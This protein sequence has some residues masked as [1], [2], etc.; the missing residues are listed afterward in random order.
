MLSVETTAEYDFIKSNFDS[1]IGWI[2]AT[3]AATER[4]WLWDSGAAVTLNH[5]TP[6]K[7]KNAD[8]NCHCMAVNMNWNTW[9]W[10]DVNCDLMYRSVCEIDLSI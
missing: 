3:D 4:V 5:C 9:Q 6:G 10:D 8:W 1:G 7:P 2:G